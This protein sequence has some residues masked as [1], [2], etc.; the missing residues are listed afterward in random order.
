MRNEYKYIGKHSTPEKSLKARLLMM[1]QVPKHIHLDGDSAE[2]RY[3]M[4]FFADTI[5]D[6]IE[7]EEQEDKNNWDNRRWYQKQIDKCSYLLNGMTTHMVWTHIKNEP[8]CD[9]AE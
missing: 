1:E 6:L 2:L 8:V 7:R 5:L 9:N 4:G 3:W